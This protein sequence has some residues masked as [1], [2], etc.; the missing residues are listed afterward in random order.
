MEM[1]TEF[2]IVAQTLVI[3]LGQAL[4]VLSSAPRG[5]GLLRSR[6]ILNHQVPANP[7]TPAVAMAR[8]WEDPARYLGRVARDLDVERRCVAFMTAVPLEH[9]VLIHEE[10]NDEK[11]LWVEAFVTVGLSN[12]VRAGEPVPKVTPVHPYPGTINIVLI[13]N[14]T[15]PPPA[16]VGALQVAVESK[17]ATLQAEQVKSWTGRPGATGTGTDAL[18]IASGDGPFVRYSG[19]H[20]KLG[21]MVGRVVGLAVHE[22]IIRWNRWKQHDSSAALR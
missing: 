2:R 4:P 1:R 20:T 5:G 13:T 9:L 7:I 11:E 3:D 8:V 17:T 6:Y 21:S 14:A 16:L 15:L 22:G 10:E 12:A 19:T 18:A